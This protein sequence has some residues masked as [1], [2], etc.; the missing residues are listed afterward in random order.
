MAQFQFTHTSMD[1]PDDLYRG[2]FLELYA[3]LTT[4]DMF[5]VMEQTVEASPWHREANVKVHTDMV[6]SEYVQRTDAAKIQWERTD[7]LGAAACAFHDTGKPAAKIQ[8]YRE[9]RGNYFAFHG[10]EVVSSR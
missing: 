1:R 4:T 8:K 10:H 9:D 3:Q 6:V 5:L 2:A 7:F